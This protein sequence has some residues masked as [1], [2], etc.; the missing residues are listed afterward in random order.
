MGDC[1][2]IWLATNSA[3]LRERLLASLPQHPEIE[4]L[5]HCDADE[6]SLER[7]LGSCTPDVLLVDWPDSTR[8]GRGLE[9]LR[10]IA[11]LA[12]KVLLVVDSAPDS[13]VEAIL[14]H[15]LNGYVLH[16]SSLG[17]CIRAIGCVREGEVWI[18]RARLAK[19][20]TRIMR[21]HVARPAEGTPDAGEAGQYTERER[22]IVGLVRRGMSNKQIG[23]ELGIVE[24]TVKKH[25]QH[26]Y[27][28]VGVRRR[29]MLAL[30][31]V[32]SSSREA[33]W[34]S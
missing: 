4:L 26:I 18:P 33:G 23:R 19:A 28:K 11:Q 2:R 6:A 15:R 16:A 9:A 32:V 24:D 20:I 34:S 31:R 12:P 10:K 22:Q 8:R 14:L 1:T 7:H 30:A 5:G 13:L 27:D 3:L 21:E 29:S 17:E 25:L